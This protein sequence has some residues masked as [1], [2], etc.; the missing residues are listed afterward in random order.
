M[1]NRRRTAFRAILFQIFYF[2]M[3]LKL[4][5][6]LFLIPLIAFGFQLANAQDSQ[7]YQ[8][9]PI[10]TNKKCGLELIK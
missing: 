5:I 3:K 2:F 7:F 9:E 10:Q 8:P 6:M 1:E 4:K